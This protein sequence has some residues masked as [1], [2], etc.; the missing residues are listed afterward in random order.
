MKVLYSSWYKDMRRVS[1][2]VK[3]LN[4]AGFDGIEFSIDYP[5]CYKRPLEKA[6]FEELTKE[7]LLYGIHLPWRDI[8]LASPIEEVRKASVA[9]IMNCLKDVLGLD[10]YYV[11]VHITTDQSDCGFRDKDCIEAG[12]KSLAE[13]AKVTV[14][15][16]IDLLV[17][18]THNRCCSGE[19][20]IPYLIKDIEGVDVCLDAAHLISRR[21]RRWGTLYTVSALLNDLPPAM[22]DRIKLVHLHG[23]AVDLE[24]GIIITHQIPK[25]EFIREM[26]NKIKELGIA[27]RIKG[28]VI[29]AFRDKDAIKD[30]TSLRH[31]V[32]EVRNI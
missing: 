28:V 27:S 12:R 23:Y 6:F 19:E 26:F 13:I 22:I 11:L 9:V 2:L 7:G 8:A 16:G 32:K 20:Q 4:K 5:L 15:E 3:E 17:E 30:L 18:T 29:E 10:P 24:T 31:I 1:D 14:D 21:L 25:K